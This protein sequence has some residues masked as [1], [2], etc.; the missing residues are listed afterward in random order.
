ML[1]SK[2]VTSETWVSSIKYSERRFE[3]LDNSLKLSTE[4]FSNRLAGSSPSEGINFISVPS[5]IEGNTFFRAP[6]AD[7]R[8]HHL[9][10]TE[11][12]LINYL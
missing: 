2:D 5:V 8:P 1:F 10:Q 12:Y 6:A 4:F 3:F 9:H 7:P 11:N